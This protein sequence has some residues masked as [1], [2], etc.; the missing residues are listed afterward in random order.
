MHPSA[1]GSGAESARLKMKSV[2][3]GS[4]G[5]IGGRRSTT[6]VVGGGVANSGCQEEL[7]RCVVEHEEPVAPGP[8]AREPSLPSHG[9]DDAAAGDLLD[10]AIA[11]I[12][13]GRVASLDA[14]EVDRVSRRGLEQWNSHEFVASSF[15]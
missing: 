11:R 10:A 14:G 9:V 5:G 6:V 1:V 15:S 12:D 4:S 13:Q 8:G 3:V 7:P 2:C